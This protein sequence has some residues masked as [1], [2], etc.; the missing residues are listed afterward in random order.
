MAYVYCFLLGVR[1]LDVMLEHDLDVLP[2]IGW[3]GD[4]SQIDMIKEKLINAR[5]A[6]LSAPVSSKIDLS[7]EF[8]SLCQ[9]I[10]YRAGGEAKYD[11][12][13]ALID[14]YKS[15]LNERGKAHEL[16]NQLRSGKSRILSAYFESCS[17]VCR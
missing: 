13:L 6:L 17:C 8:E 5:R 16:V 1:L 15:A 3:D 9:K 10:S 2:Y 4:R 12:M 11:L 7:I 14:T